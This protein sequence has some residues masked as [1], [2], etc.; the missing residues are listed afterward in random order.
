MGG[1]S[2]V[3]QQPVS[4][5]AGECPDFGL[6]SPT[7]ILNNRNSRSQDSSGL[8]LPEDLLRRLLIRLGPAC[9]LPLS[10]V[11]R[12]WDAICSTI[13]S[14]LTLCKTRSPHCTPLTPTNL[15][16]CC[17][18]FRSL[19]QLAFE[20][21]GGGRNGVDFSTELFDCMSGVLRSCCPNLSHFRLMRC[22]INGDQLRDI[23]ECLPELV[24]LVVD[25]CDNVVASQI[26][27]LS[28]LPML[29]QLGLVCM[30]TLS[31]KHVSAIGQTATKLQYL[32]ISSCP[33]LSSRCF[34]DEL[35]GIYA[36][37][38]GSCEWMD[39]RALTAITS[40][41]SGLLTINLSHCN[42]VTDNGVKSIGRLKAL[43]SLNLSWCTN[44]GGASINVISAECTN[45]QELFM[46]GCTR[47]KAEDVLDLSASHIATNTL[48][49]ISVARCPRVTDM[50]IAA[51][52]KRCKVMQQLDASFCPKVSEAG[53]IDMINHA[54]HLQLICVKGVELDM[55]LLHKHTQGPDKPQLI[56]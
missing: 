3:Q 11:C 54:P 29:Q 27:G 28:C 34:D 49:S 10:G 32:D 39:D 35:S 56:M 17:L 55:E 22:Q 5:S 44:V 41:C 1:G 26:L 18:R 19:K 46:E 21:S 52:G 51:L 42:A 33:A 15:Q 9:Y 4:P 20:D 48:R 25:R 6:C 36:L 23:T 30:K 7:T 8:I 24:S 43:Q 38:V 47:I 40:T 14:S 13:S 16:S 12:T 2:S 53:L 37:S 45:L 31:N 50:A